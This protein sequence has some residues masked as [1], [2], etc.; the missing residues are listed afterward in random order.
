MSGCELTIPK[1][2][3]SDS[4]IRFKVNIIFSLCES[5]VDRVVIYNWLIEFG[6]CFLKIKLNFL[7]TLC[8][9][10]SPFLGRCISC[11]SK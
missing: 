1:W 9:C 7:P 5:R 6:R 2:I 4:M 3:I 11:L 8:S 10:I